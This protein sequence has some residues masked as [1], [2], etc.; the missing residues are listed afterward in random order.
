M[1][2]KQY[3]KLARGSEE[4]SSVDGVLVYNLKRGL[5]FSPPCR[6]LAAALRLPVLHYPF[7]P[8]PLGFVSVSTDSVGL[9]VSLCLLVVPPQGHWTECRR[10]KR[11]R[12]RRGR[13]RVRMSP[14]AYPTPT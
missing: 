5:D 14:Q 8:L 10:G 2:T 6:L 4:T 3:S 13:S 1:R 12:G 11:M 9:S 7:L